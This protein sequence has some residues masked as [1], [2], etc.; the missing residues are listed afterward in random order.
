MPVSRGTRAQSNEYATNQ[1]YNGP[2]PR[3]HGDKWRT[4][5]N[6]TNKKYI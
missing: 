5:V 2:Q 3:V 1:L 4:E 6:G